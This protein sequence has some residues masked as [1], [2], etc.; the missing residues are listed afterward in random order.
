MRCHGAAAEI[1]AV[2]KA[3]GHDNEV[4]AGRQF[5]LGVPDHV[6]LAARHKLERARHV[7]LAVDAWK[8]EDG[9]FHRLNL[10][11][12]HPTTSTR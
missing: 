7:A 5:M 4:G 1:V 11:P 3:A 12:S 10:P 2:G 9:G 8:N 6:G